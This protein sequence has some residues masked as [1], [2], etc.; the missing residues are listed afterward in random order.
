MGGSSGGGGNTT[1][2][3]K[4][5]PWAGQQDY[6][7][8]GF[9]QALNQYNS[10]TP[11]YY[12]GQTVAPLSN[13]TNMAM[14]LTTQRALNGNSL[15]NASQDQLTNT[16]NGN[17]LNSNP[18]LDANFKAG[19]DSITKAYNDAVNGQTSGFAGGG[20]IGSGMQAFYQN[21]QNDTL[22]K[23]LNNLYGQTY[24]NNYNTERQNQLN[25]TQLA[26]QFAAQ[27]YIN[28]D[29]L[30]NVGAT[31]DQR[32]QNLINADIDRWNYG[33]NLPAN[34]LSQ[35][36]NL[37]QGNYG[38][39]ASSSGTYTPKFSASGM[40]GNTL[41]GALGGA[42]LGMM[43]GGP[44]G[45]AVGLGL[46]GTFGGLSSAFC[47]RRLK[48]NVRQIEIAENNLN[49]YEFSYIGDTE[50]RHIGYMADEVMEKYPYAVTVD[51]SGYLK[52]NYAMLS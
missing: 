10:S 2:V 38:G 46:G 14:G 13:T 1:T 52:V 27:D 44:M 50:T 30:S 20:R 49:I 35:Y 28:L 51:N 17:Y 23:N 12:P 26:P 6:L 4:S 5:E 48:T 41:G 40:F 33:Q 34:K 47:D 31:Q 15:M 36:M 18:F 22:A 45:A 39:D 16:V 37:V 9:Q 29:A 25:A 8:T 24:Y 7:K 43:L 32:N 19:T 42:G 11:S 3:S 21:Q